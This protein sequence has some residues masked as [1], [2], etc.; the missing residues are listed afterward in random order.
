MVVLDLN[1]Q[2][3]EFVAGR[4]S[5]ITTPLLHRFEGDIKYTLSRC[6]VTG[7]NDNPHPTNS[8]I[9]TEMFHIDR[10]KINM[11]KYT[12]I[13]TECKF[14][15][16][17]NH[18]YKKVTTF[19]PFGDAEYN[20][21]EFITSNGDINIGSDVWIGNNCTIMSGI[22]I[23]HGA[24]IASGAVITKD[25]EPYTIVGG[26][27]AKPIKKRFDDETIKDLL[28]IK[29]WDLDESIL[30]ENR[31]LLFSQDVRGFIEKIKTLL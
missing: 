30:I 16:S 4:K 2:V 24:V 25:V 21:E 28:E 3:M 9:Y 1:Q 6:R 26:S 15:L 23:G 22:T 17:G 11:G 8:K 14:M 10:Y 27:P 12:S 5:I 19:L 31:H 20:I 13:S 18:D 7:N 29:W